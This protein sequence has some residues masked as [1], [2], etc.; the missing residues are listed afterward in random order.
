MWIRRRM[1]FTVAILQ[2]FT[3]SRSGPS[4]LLLSSLSEENRYLELSQTFVPER[5]W[6]QRKIF[7]PVV[8]DDAVDFVLSLLKSST[9]SHIYMQREHSTEIRIWIRIFLVKTVHSTW[10]MKSEIVSFCNCNEI[11]RFKRLGNGSRSCLRTCATRSNVASQ[12]WFIAI[13]AGF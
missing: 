1:N 8:L 6:R 7:S 12:C 3:S 5:L 4:P 9:R 2:F 13:A 11:S 10:K